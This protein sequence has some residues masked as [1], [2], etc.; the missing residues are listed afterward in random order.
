VL[1]GIVNGIEES[2]WDPSTD[3]DIARNY[4][5]STLREGKAANKLAL[6]REL[7]LPEDPD[8]PLL[9]FIGRLD[10]QKGADLIL[11]AAPWI[12]QQKG[13]QLVCLGSGTPD[14]EGGLRWL[15][16]AYPN[17][18]RGWVGF[19]VA[20]SHR[21]TAAADMLLMPSRFE[22]CGLNQLYAMAYGTV[23]FDPFAAGGPKGTGWTFS[24]CDA[25]AL[26]AALGNALRTYR[27]HRAEF[28]GIALRGMARDS[29]WEQAATQYEQVFEWA[30]VDPPYAR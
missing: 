14:L 1:S 18:A 22:P 20:L 7:G 24:P 2:E 28:D 15:E 26:T 21:I 27:E 29:S 4:S 11:Q 30:L 25:G 9:A 16:A 8:A 17:Q 23:D 3:R 12:M 19:N 10:Y 6:Q 13:A 5:A